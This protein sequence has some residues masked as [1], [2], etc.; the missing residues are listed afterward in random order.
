MRDL[1]IAFGS[2]SHAK[3][4]SNKKESFDDLKTRLCRTHGICH[5]EG[6]GRERKEIDNGG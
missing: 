6:K 3:V 4:W 2:S 5:L 1:P